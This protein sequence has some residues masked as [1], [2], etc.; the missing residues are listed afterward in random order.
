MANLSSS[1]LAELAYTANE[2]FFQ[3]RVGFNLISTNHSAISG[4]PYWN[5]CIKIRVL[6]EIENF[7]ILSENDFSSRISDIL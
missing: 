1:M 6:H 5:Y 4:K 2:N 7:F 3:N